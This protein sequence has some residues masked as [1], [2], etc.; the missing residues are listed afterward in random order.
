MLLE[1]IID[2]SS[3]TVPIEDPFKL[4]VKAVISR[5]EQLAAS[6]GTEIAGL[7]LKGL[8]PQMIRG[9]AGCENGCPA[10]AKRLISR[11][12]SGFQ[13]NYVEGGIL[14]ASATAVAGSLVQLKMFPDF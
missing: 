1:A 8:I 14:T 10:D 3:I 12:Y 5:I 13:L 11:G 4:D 2:G 6:K 7:D 9:I